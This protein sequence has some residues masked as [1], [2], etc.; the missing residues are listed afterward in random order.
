MRVRTLLH[1]TVRTS[2]LAAFAVK[3]LRVR[4][5]LLILA[6]TATGLEIPCLSLRAFPTVGTDTLAE[7]VTVGEWIFACPASWWT[8]AFA[9]LGAE[10]VWRSTIELFGALVAF[11]ALAST[12]AEVV[13]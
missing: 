6:D 1:V 5:V 11:F 4:T 7:V 8:H 3:D 9:G 13:W 2:A 12:V 10:D